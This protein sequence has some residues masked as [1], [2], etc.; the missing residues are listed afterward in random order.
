MCGVNCNG[1]QVRRDLIQSRNTYRVQGRSREDYVSRRVTFLRYILRHDIVVRLV[2]SRLAFYRVERFF[3][4][5]DDAF[6]MATNEAYGG[7]SLFYALRNKLTTSHRSNAT[8]T[9]GNSNTPFCVATN[10]SNELNGSV[11]VDVGPLWFSIIITCNVCHSSR[12]N[13]KEG[14]I[15]GL[16]SLVLI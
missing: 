3:Y 14:L 11:A 4:R 9:R 12:L 2:G 5:N 6:P 13:D 8:S 1:F 15:R 10:V 7:V 16:R